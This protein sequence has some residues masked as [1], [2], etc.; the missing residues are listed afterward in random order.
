M[1]VMQTIRHEM[2]ADGPVGELPDRVTWNPDTK[3][4]RLQAGPAV[5]WHVDGEWDG[6]M[7]RDFYSSA[8]M[9]R[10]DCNGRMT[11]GYGT[12]RLITESIHNDI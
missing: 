11:R 9:T 12:G 1:T 4:L 8:R 2:S 5:N 10:V 6:I 3:V 7:E